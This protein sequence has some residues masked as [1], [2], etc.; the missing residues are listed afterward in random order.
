MK[1]LG[2]MLAAT[3]RPTAPKSAGQLHRAARHK[4]RKLGRDASH[5]ARNV[6][7]SSLPLR[8][9]RFRRR[10]MPRTGQRGNQVP[11]ANRV[12]IKQ[13]GLMHRRLDVHEL[14]YRVRLRSDVQTSDGFM[15]CALL[16]YRSLILSA[17]PALLLANSVA[18]AAPISVPLPPNS[19]NATAEVYFSPGAH[20]DLAIAS[21][22]ATANQRVWIAGYYFTSTAIAK[23]LHQAHERNVDVRVVLDRSQAT[24]K[25]SSATYFY[26][27]GVPIK[28]NARYPIMHA[29]FFV[30]D[31][32][33][34]GF[35]SMN[36]TRGGADKNSENFNIFRR[37][38]Q[39]T[40]TYAAEFSK[41]ER[42]SQS[43]RPGMVFDQ[44]DAAERE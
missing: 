5:R 32:D 16:F 29:K 42:E 2:R 35:G 19:A 26:N 25:Y 18:H 28:I 37:W 40:E 30:I 20:S 22:I 24:Q 27:N 4:A 43:Y 13:S 38:P 7:G 10:R 14:V 11:D 41:L 21:L 23:A 6:P 34:V 33:L 36:F 9:I 12:A 8:R 15:E 1:T 44:P 31:R 3:F 39:L 17:L